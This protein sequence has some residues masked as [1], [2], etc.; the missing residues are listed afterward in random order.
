[1]IGGSIHLP[2]LILLRR[3]YL[4]YL[5]F[6]TQFWFA[7]LRLAASAGFSRRIEK[8]YLTNKKKFGSIESWLRRKILSPAIGL[9]FTLTSTREQAIMAIRRSRSQSAPAELS[10]GSDWQAYWLRRKYRDQKDFSY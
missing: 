3:L 8:N 5:I 9:P 1:M 7:T 4:T 6:T 2:T 10:N